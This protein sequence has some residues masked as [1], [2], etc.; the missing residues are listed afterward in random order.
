MAS[1]LSNKYYDKA[2]K[3]PKTDVPLYKLI[4]SQDMDDFAFL[5]CSEYEN[6]E[7]KKLY[8]NEEFM[9]IKNELR[10]NE[11]MD[12]IEYISSCMCDEDRSA[13]LKILEG[14]YIVECD[15]EKTRLIKEINTQPQDILITD[16]KMREEFVDDTQTLRI[17]SE[18]I[19]Q[20]LQEK[21]FSL[22]GEAAESNIEKAYGSLRF[23]YYNGYLHIFRTEIPLKELITHKLLKDENEPKLKLLEADYDRPIRHN[24][25]KYILFQNELQKNMSIDQR[26]LT[27]AELILSQEYIIA[28][29]PEPRYQ[30][31]CL[32][33][34]IKLW[35][36]DEILQNNIRKIKLLINQYRAISEKKYNQI[37][38]IR[39]S[40][41]MY[42]RY[43]KESATNVFKK[44]M[45]YFSIYFQA[46]GWKKNPPSFFRVVND[47]VS[48]TN[49]NQTLKLYYKRISE[50]NCQK[51][52]VFSEKYE[53]VKSPGYNTDILEQYNKLK[54]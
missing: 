46:I 15:N 16:T 54:R 10:I 39:F 11:T 45:Y 51:N 26:L 14:T 44:I 47:L 1:T 28:L 6:E 24:V 38:G 7:L 42:P 13:L 41:G 12:D 3:N 4:A 29:T 9:E 2:T 34:I 30:L 19:K 43:G 35:Y 48:Y 5:N 53:V 17:E 33:R 8:E 49:C 31:W 23:I 50:A 18:K 37:N 22:E 25:L 20:Y 32:I 40:I 36:A 21:V 52:E 27:E